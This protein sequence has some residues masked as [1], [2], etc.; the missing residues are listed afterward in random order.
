MIQK[1]NKKVKKARPTPSS[2]PCL[3]FVV[4]KQ[5]L[6][7]LQKPLILLR[8]IH[9]MDLLAFHKWIGSQLCSVQIF[10]LHI[11]IGN[12]AIVIGGVIV[13]PFVHIAARRINGEFIFAFVHIT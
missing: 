12:L 13:N 11:D 9:E 5:F 4:A 10:L 3:I 1:P 2:W 8:L 6:H 7:Y